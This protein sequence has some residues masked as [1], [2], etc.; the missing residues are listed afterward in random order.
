MT[1]NYIS[2]FV[3][4]FIVNDDMVTT[5]TKNLMT[6]AA[7]ALTVLDDLRNFND[8]IIMKTSNTERALATI[9]FIKRH[10]ADPAEIVQ[11]RR[12]LLFFAQIADAKSAAEV[13][14]VLT[15]YT[16]P[17]VSFA[18]KRERYQTHYLITAN[19]GYGVGGNVNAGSTETKNN[20]GIYAPIGF[21]VSRGLGNGSSW[22]FRRR[23]PLSLF[24]TRY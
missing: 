19:L 13:K 3:D 24:P 14:E 15:A 16:M 12:Y 5:T 21:E 11:Y 8:D 17:A 6:S 9:E 22:S 4:Y 10:S 23:Q 7:G 18:V 20:S 1:N 2:L